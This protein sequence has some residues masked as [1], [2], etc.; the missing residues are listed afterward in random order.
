MPS[1]FGVDFCHLCLSAFLVLARCLIHYQI[2][3]LKLPDRFLDYLITREV[4]DKDRLL[5]TLQSKALRENNKF[6]VCYSG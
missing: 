2:D 4:N 6:N 1:D 5:A 3:P